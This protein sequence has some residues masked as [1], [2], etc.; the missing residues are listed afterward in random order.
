MSFRDRFR[1]DFGI[2]SCKFGLVSSGFG[3]A[4][5]A[6]ATAAAAETWV[7]EESSQKF[8]FYDVFSTLERSKSKD[9]LCLGRCWSVFLKTHVFI[10]F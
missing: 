7:G 9:G 10:R 8:L 5:A 2:I 6:A 4:A 3:L 1:T